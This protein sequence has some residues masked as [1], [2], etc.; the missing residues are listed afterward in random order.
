MII[1]NGG[2]DI[3]SNG[4]KEHSSLFTGIQNGIV[5]Q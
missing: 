3:I 1:S 2:K 5:I 4:G